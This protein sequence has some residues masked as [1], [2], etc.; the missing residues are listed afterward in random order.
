MHAVTAVPPLRAPARPEIDFFPGVPDLA[1]FPVRDWAWA[2][3]EAGP[4]GAHRCSPAMPTRPATN[5]CGR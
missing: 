3:A 1:S 4:P 5:G 2:V